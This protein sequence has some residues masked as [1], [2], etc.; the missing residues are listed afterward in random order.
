M[1]KYLLKRILFSL[2]SLVVVTGAVM[3]LIYGAMDKSMILSG[4]SAYSKRTGNDKTTYAYAKYQEYGYIYYTTFSSWLSNEIEDKT[5]QEYADALSAVQ[6]N[7]A[8]GQ[9]FPDNDYCN[10]FVTLYQKSGYTVEWLPAT[11]NRKGVRVS[12]GYL[13]ATKD[14][15]LFVR[16]GEF[17]G[18]L[19]T[20]ETI[21]DV[22]D[23]NLPESERY[24]RWEW[25]PY[26]NMPALVGNGT[27][28][29]YLIYFDNKFPFIHFNFFH[30]NLGKSRTYSGTEMVDL[31]TART[32]APLTEE[33]ILPKDIYEENPPTTE[34]NLDFHTVTYS[35]LISSMTESIYGEG[36]HYINATQN[37]S[38]F[39][40]IGNSFVIGILATIISY[41]IG[42][43]IGIWMARKKNKLPD[44]IGNLYIIFLMSVPSLAYIFMFAA[45]GVNVFK[46]PYKWDLAAIP[47]LA[48]IMPI[49]SLALPAIGGLMRWI[50]R[51]MIDQENADY[52]K[53]ARSQ[54]LT[55]REIF[56]KHIFRNAMIFLV[57]GIPMDIM[58]C[59]VGAMI[60]ERVYGVPGVGGMLTSAISS[61]DNGLIVGM[62]I[63]YTALSILAL[64]LGDLLLAKYDPRVSFT[65]GKA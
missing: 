34:S 46:L 25:D 38:G 41:I 42:L 2:F 6:A 13:V 1:R 39:T 23:E 8:E 65:D 58:A 30:I 16:L 52:V 49:V 3:F 62:T 20:F 21:H 47:V 35:P 63:F 48:F 12:S 60:T 11:Y 36:N 17:F 28:H 33:T 27:T 22:E 57:H 53:F 32:G 29:R 50:R 5:S 14:K 44:K 31:L 43:P 59:L 40:R 10:T 15:N 24:I 61:S 64:L 4:D 18:H 19:I 54:G 55:E 9:E 26:S 51:F 45:L 7:K 56:S 37:L